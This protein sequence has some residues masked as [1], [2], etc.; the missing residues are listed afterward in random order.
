M[1]MA[2]AISI[3]T[4]RSTGP[5]FWRKAMSPASQSDVSRRSILAALNTA[6]YPKDGRKPATQ[7]GGPGRNRRDHVGVIRAVFRIMV[8]AQAAAHLYTQL[9]HRSDADLARRGLRRSDL[10]RAAHDALTR[11]S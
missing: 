6:S 7:D 2:E 5:E 1:V 10:P 11:E 4:S 3:P 9:R 8:R